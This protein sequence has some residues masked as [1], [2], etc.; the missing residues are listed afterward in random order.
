MV[1][2]ADSAALVAALRA[3]ND[4]LRG[5]IAELDKQ[6]Q[7][8]RVA[9]RELVGSPEY[10]MVAPLRRVQEWLRLA[11]QDRRR[12]GELRAPGAVRHPGRDSSGPLVGIAAPD[13]TDSQAQRSPL[14]ARTRDWVAGAQLAPPKRLPARPPSGRRVLVIAHVFY[15][16]LWPE[17]ADH[18]ERIPEPF[19]LVVT[20][21]AGISDGMAAAVI[22][23]FPDCLVHTVANRGR[24]M[25]P[26]LEVLDLGVVSG[27]A[28]ILKVHTKKSAHRLDGSSWRS[29]M[30]DSL[31]PPGAGT[32]LIIELLSQDPA[33]AI[34][35]PEGY[36]RGAEFWGGCGPAVAAIA[37]R[38]GVGF[39]PRAVWFPAGSMF[40]CRP[41]VLAGLQAPGL[42]Q[43]DFE[44]EVAA[45]DA[46]TAH[47]LERYIGVVAAV[48]GA[49][50][51]STSEVASRLAR[52]RDRA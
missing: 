31:C 42:T 5:R 3:E 30:L 35:A 13:I 49:E 18:I 9:H 37:H 47:A 43:D 44:Y 6:V 38:A 28:A 8:L 48:A 46:T 41:E 4:A 24:D 51:V 12:R 19:D 32:S 27:H 34:V 23:R 14:L 36:I 11:R 2:P 33:A 7:A 21:V 52:L 16:D 45:L 10:R 20:V 1:E 15:P 40:W 25:L 50:V 39:D 26:L 17:L 29:A 22:A